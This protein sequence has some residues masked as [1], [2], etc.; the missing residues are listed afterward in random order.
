MKVC[1]DIRVYLFRH[2]VSRAWAIAED[3]AGITRIG[4]VMCD[5]AQAISPKLKRNVPILQQLLRS[6]YEH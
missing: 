3:N 2:F 6:I 5:S 4:E 1:T